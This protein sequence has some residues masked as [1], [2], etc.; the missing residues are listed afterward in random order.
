VA[1]CHESRSCFPKRNIRFAV[2]KGIGYGFLSVCMAY[3]LADTQGDGER[4]I[5][6]NIRGCCGD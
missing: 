3:A 6:G 4:G 1:V 2:E 5:Q